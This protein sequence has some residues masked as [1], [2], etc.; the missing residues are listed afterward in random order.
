M[1][2]SFQ[3][4]NQGRSEERDHESDRT[5]F[6]ETQESR[7]EPTDRYRGS[8]T[9]TV[10]FPTPCPNPVDIDTLANYWWIS[11]QKNGDCGSPLSQKLFLCLT[12]NLYY[13]DK[14]CCDA[15]EQ[16]FRYLAMSK[17]SYEQASRFLENTFVR[18][19]QANEHESTISVILPFKRLLGVGDRELGSK[20]LR[21]FPALVQLL[22]KLLGI[23]TK[24][25]FELSRDP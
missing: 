19:V 9:S 24:E 11:V 21:V 14:L 6:L 18:V 23:E 7:P 1:E 3:T 22:P 13:R 10:E 5:G 2:R 4:R 8:D 17:D 15:I 20:Q 12:D 16:L 25:D